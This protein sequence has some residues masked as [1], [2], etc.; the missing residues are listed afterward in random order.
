MNLKTLLLEKDL[1]DF[2]SKVKEKVRI[3]SQ[4]NTIEKE[5]DVKFD[6]YGDLVEIKKNIGEILENLP[7][8]ALQIGEE[9]GS[10]KGNR[11]QK[12]VVSLL[13]LTLFK[14]KL[15]GGKNQP[16]GFVFFYD[17]KKPRWYLIEVK[18]FKDKKGD[19]FYSMKES[20]SQ[21]RKYA[22]SYKKSDI[23]ER[24]ETPSYIVIANDFNYEDENEV[25]IINELE[26]DTKMKIV[27]LPLKSIIR[28]VKS[29]LGQNIAHLPIEKIEPLF[30]TNRYI[31]ISVIDSLYTDLI[32]YNK[33]RDHDILKT[34]RAYI[35]SKGL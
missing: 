17:D 10:L 11:F 13:N 5:A 35:E 25:K 2:E 30:Q 14:A 33:N 29:F 20:A 8:Y 9:H 24:I 1:C 6:R 27:L 21:I 16:D 15:A 26:K 31:D 34:T 19:G 32:K 12:Y 7:R 28:I 3:N 22:E 23:S 18:S 4:K